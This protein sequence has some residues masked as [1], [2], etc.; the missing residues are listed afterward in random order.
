[1]GMFDQNS[2]DSLTPEEALES[3]VGEGKKYA[4]PAELAKAVLHASNHISV[5][6]AEN[7]DLRTKGDSTASI[8]ELLKQMQTQQTTPQPAARQDQPGNAQEPD[9]DKLI[10]ER[11]NNKLGERDRAS[12]QSAV[13]KHFQDTYGGKAAEFFGKLANELGLS[14]Q[15]LEEMSASRPQAVIN[16]TGKLFVADRQP[17]S[18]LKGDQGPGRSPANGA[19]PSTRSELL[20][21]AADNKLG[22]SQKY[23]LLNREMSRAAREGRLNE[24]NR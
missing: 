5:L 6:E 22:R 9:W 19:V 24:W 21:Y 18:S 13:A 12:N 20:K 14:K 1:M 11:L 17:A 10:E 7:A 2:E 3:L 4:T 23:E 16:L 15:E 8:H